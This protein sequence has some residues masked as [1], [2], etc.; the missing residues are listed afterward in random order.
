[1]L[2]IVLYVTVH[3]ASTILCDW[4]LRTLKKVR[5]KALTTKNKPVQ[6]TRRPTL[7]VTCQI[8]KF[9][10]DTPHNAVSTSSKSIVV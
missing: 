9:Q 2:C 3:A 4:V 10:R 8:D 1:M 6:K 5:L 7:A